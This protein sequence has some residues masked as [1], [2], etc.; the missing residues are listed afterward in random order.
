MTRLGTP[1]IKQAGS[2][3]HNMARRNCGAGIPACRP[4][5]FQKTK[6]YRPG[7]TQAEPL[8]SEHNGSGR[9]VTG[10]NTRV[11]IGHTPSRWRRSKTAADSAA[12]TTRDALRCLCV[13][14]ALCGSKCDVA[15]SLRPLRPRGSTAMQR[16]L[17]R[18]DVCDECDGSKMRCLCAPLC[19]SVP[20]WFNCDVET[21]AMSLRPLRPRG[22]TA[23][24]PD[25]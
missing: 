11:R 24:S 2:L 22:S 21:S 14:C 19:V 16:C 12:Q 23:M 15:M 17:R 10:T 4:T 8:C 18:C 5:T 13:L 6:G 7:T 3:L 20:L 9:W 1:S 25:P